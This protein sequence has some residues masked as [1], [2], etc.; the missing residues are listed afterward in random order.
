M[1]EPVPIN[2]APTGMVPTREMTPHVPITPTEI[3]ED[4]RT[5][6]EIGITAVHLHA[7]D[8]RTGEPT[9]EKEVFAEII[10]GIRDF[11]PELVVC[12]SL[13]GR[14]WDALEK[15]TDA[16]ELTGNRKPDM[17]SLTLSSMNFSDEASVNSPDM[18]EALAE[19][20]RDRG[21]L[22]EIETFDLGMVNYANY[23]AERDVLEP[24]HYCNL[25]LG[26]VATAQADL[27]HAGTMI[28]ELPADSVWSL[29]GIGDAQLP[30]NALAVAVGGGVRVGIEDAIY[31]DSE[32]EQLATNEAL[33]E[34]VHELA[35]LNGRDVMH[36]AKFRDRLDLQ[37]GNG[38]YGR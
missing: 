13:S 24:P 22:P 19:A 10:D 33:V 31:F 12:V 25:L 4:V 36:P 7:R 34:R 1:T 26:N 2:F 6:H 15:R 38:E 3:V 37:P 18:V 23:L 27:V 29:A 21:V 30:M 28:R 11:A 20:M 32:R 35:A 14:N 8:P 9:W 5:V 17:G 16:L